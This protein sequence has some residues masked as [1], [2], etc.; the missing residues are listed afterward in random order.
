MAILDFLLGRK[1]RRMRASRL[2]EAIDEPFGRLHAAIRESGAAQL[3]SDF[4]AI[5]QRF[6]DCRLHRPG[7]LASFPAKDLDALD[8]FVAGQIAPARPVLAE[9]GAALERV[10]R[11]WRRDDLVKA[12]AGGGLRALSE[13]RELEWAST[14]QD[15][16]FRTAALVEID[17]ACADVRGEL[18]HIAQSPSLFW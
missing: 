5:W 8:R 7:E 16:L 9:I 11:D 18:T 10:R 4:E 2:L 15:R 17:L 14:A 3:G 1:G 6:A 12:A 13:F